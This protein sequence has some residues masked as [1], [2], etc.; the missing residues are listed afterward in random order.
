MTWWVVP[1][2]VLL[3]IAAAWW[4]LARDLGGPEE[5]A[6]LLRAHARS[7]GGRVLVP[8]GIGVALWCFVPIT[9]LMLGCALVFTPGEAFAFTMV[10]AVLGALGSWALGR[11]AAGPVLERLRGEK[12]QRLTDFLRRR[13]F[14]AT[15]AMRL[16]PVGGFSLLNVFAGAV[17]V[18]LGG[19]VLGNV[20]GVLPAAV[21]FTLLGGV[22]QAPEHRVLAGL[23]VSAV[24]ALLW[25][26]RRRFARTGGGP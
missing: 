5:V 17:R 22:V 21:L 23:G 16:L 1:G 7:V 18:P 3:G 25:L 14:R 19:Y 6:A 15:V 9:A 4:F 20:V 2:V 26:V 10:G 8:V 24:V 13:P 11:L 12:W